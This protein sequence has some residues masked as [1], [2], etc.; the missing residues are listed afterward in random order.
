MAPELYIGSTVS[1]KTD[2]YALGITL[3][4]TICVMCRSKPYDHVLERAWKAWEAGRI[5]EEFDPSLFDMSQLT[6]I[7]RCV[8]LGLVCAQPNPVDRPIMADVLSMLNGEKELPTPNNVFNFGLEEEAPDG[9]LS[10]P[11]MIRR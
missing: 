10:N 2:V 11:T 9:G 8:Q 5:E 1:R 6:E 7:K 3:L 4:A